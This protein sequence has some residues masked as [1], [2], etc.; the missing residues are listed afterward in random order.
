MSVNERSFIMVK[1][2]AV[3]RGLIGQILSRFESSGLKIIAMKFINVTNELAE[4]H[5]A[6][7]KGKPFYD[8]LVKFITSSPV[9]SLVVEGLNAVNVGRK[10]VGA[11]DPFNSNPGT[12]RGDFGLDIG[13]NLVHASD[14]VENAKIEINVYFSDEEIINWEPINEQWLYE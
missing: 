6:I 9:V 13:R 1:P 14:S 2:D 12:I 4:N 8:K 3:Q 7:H 11:T 5:Y 10:L